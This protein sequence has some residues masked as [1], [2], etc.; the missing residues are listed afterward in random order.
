MAQNLELRVLKNG[1][2][3]RIIDPAWPNHKDMHTMCVGLAFE[4]ARKLCD[5]VSEISVQWFD[6]ERN[7]YFCLASV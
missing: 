5:G 6:S 2:V 1:E 4:A 7:K 3:Q